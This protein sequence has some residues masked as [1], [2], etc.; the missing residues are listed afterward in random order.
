MTKELLGRSLIHVRHRDSL[1]ASR[2]AS[3]RGHAVGS[4]S[5]RDTQSRSSTVHVHY[6]FHPLHEHDLALV[7]TPRAVDGATTVVDPT[8]RRLKIPAWMLSP[9]AGELRLGEQARA[10]VRALLSV[11]QLL[12]D[13]LML[14]EPDAVDDSLSPNEKSR[15]RRRTS[16]AASTGRRSRGDRARVASR[17]SAHR[18]GARAKGDRDQ[19][20]GAATPADASGARRRR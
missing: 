14:P 1:P 7:H 6:R 19:A 8:G 10:G 18:A 17:A 11:V 20:H 13:R 12:A 16:G 4:T 3:A 2:P 5:G 9:E 15:E